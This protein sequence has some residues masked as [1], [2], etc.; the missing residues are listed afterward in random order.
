VAG[1]GR[2]H[3]TGKRM[4]ENYLLN[5]SGITAVLNSSKIPITESDVVNWLKQD[6]TNP[7]YYKPLKISSDDSWTEDVNGARLLED[8]FADLT[9]KQVAF[10]KT[11]HSPMLTQWLLENSPEDLRELSDLLKDIISK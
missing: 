11:I 8:L 7:K 5:P 2:I 10:D 1:C 9:S 4:F 3:F 6:K